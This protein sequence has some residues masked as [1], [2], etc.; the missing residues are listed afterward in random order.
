M[1]NILITG[2]TGFIGTHLCNHL[3]HENLTILTKSDK[4]NGV[5]TIKK[6]IQDI[7]EEDVNGI[8]EVYH[9]ASTVDNYNIHNSPYLDVNT[10]INGTIALLEACKNKPIKIVYV[11]TFFVHGNPDTLPATVESKERP[12]RQNCAPNI[13]VEFIKM[14]TGWI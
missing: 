3:K 6:N 7:N 13:F 4:V 10:N 2:G 14:Y 11:S 5:K 12:L 8:D 1:K 9:L